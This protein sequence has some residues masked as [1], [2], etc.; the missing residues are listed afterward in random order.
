MVNFDKLATTWDRPELIKR[1]HNTYNAIASE[2]SIKKS[3]CV[4]DFGSATGLLGFHFVD[5]TTLVTFADESLNM[6]N[7]VKQKAEALGVNISTI[8]TQSE[9]IKGSYDIIVSSMALHHIKKLDDT[10][11]I[12]IQHTN[13]DGHICIADLMPE[14]GSFHYPDIVAHN[15]ID[16]N[17]IKEIFMANSIDIIANKSIGFIEKTSK[18][19]ELF[20]IIGKR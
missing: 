3:D 14:D 4:L 6:I 2:I 18:K 10:L 17:I 7:Q 12:L 5:T 19:Y 8:H 11:K 16:P 9:P 15:G 1:S 13:K 20:L